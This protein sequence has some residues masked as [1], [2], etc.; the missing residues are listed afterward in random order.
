MFLPL[1]YR[2]EGSGAFYCY[3]NLLSEHRKKYLYA[4]RLV[5]FYNVLILNTYYNSCQISGLLCNRQVVAVL[6][7]ADLP[8]RR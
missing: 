1:S 6:C 3:E 7:V 5:D 8:M 2:P 4:A